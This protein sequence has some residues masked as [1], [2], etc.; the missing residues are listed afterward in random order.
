MLLSMS[1]AGSPAPGSVAWVK[2]SPSRSSRSVRPAAS[3]EKARWE[4][5]CGEEGSTLSGK[6]RTPAWGEGQGGGG[7][8]AAPV[9]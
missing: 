9:R 6:S 7:G 1:G 3:N 4:W 8:Q 5:R 2:L